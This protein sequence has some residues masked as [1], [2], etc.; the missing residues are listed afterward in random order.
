MLSTDPDRRYVRD[1]FVR[2]DRVLGVMFNPTMTRAEVQQAMRSFV[3][4]M[5][6]TF[7]RRQVEVIACYESGDQLARAATDPRTGAV[8]IAWRH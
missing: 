1:A 2:D 7:P 6:R 3:S 4:A 8:Q 5:E